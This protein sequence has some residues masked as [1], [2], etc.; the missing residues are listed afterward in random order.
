MYV[1]MEGSWDCPVNSPAHA[2]LRRIAS[3]G[4]CESADLEKSANPGIAE[5]LRIHYHVLSSTV[6]GGLA[7]R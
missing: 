3:D 6:Y 7:R 1:E 2:F 4:D 5:F